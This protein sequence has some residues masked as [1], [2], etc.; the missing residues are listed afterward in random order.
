M[1]TKQKNNALKGLKV[2]E[3]LSDRFGIGVD[4]EDISR[5]KK[6][7]FNKN[8]LFYKKIFNENEIKY[9]MS[10]KEPYHHFAVRFCAKEAFI[11]AINKPVKDYKEIKIKTKNKKP[12]ILWKG[13]THLLSLSHDKD[14]A[15]A[16][17]IVEKV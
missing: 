1:N 16:F 9:C 5:F 15:I 10:K 13:K 3:N 14:K 2:I 6:L 11:K 12:Y 7:E 4:I 17:V 8:K